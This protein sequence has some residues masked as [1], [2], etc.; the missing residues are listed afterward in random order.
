MQ[1]II[2][3]LLSIPNT[4]IFNLKCFPLPEA[5]S[6]PVIVSYNVKMC[7][8]RKGAVHIKG[9]VSTGMISI[10]VAEGTR[11]IPEMRGRGYIFL[12]KILEV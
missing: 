9:P 2:K 3:I 10:G 8:L 5:L 4:L 1:K 11:G 7:N 12:E 6:L